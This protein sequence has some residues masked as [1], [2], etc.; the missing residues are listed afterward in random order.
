M[1]FQEV[2]P[3]SVEASDGSQT[4]LRAQ[5]APVEGP[6]PLHAMLLEGWPK[7]DYSLVVK[8]GLE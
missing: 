4:S 5:G 7:T 2:E 8:P 1:L 3:V 6:C